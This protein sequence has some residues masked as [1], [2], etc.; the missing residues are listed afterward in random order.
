MFGRLPRGG[1]DRNTLPAT[2]ARKP[3]CRLPRGGVDRN[4]G[5]SIFGR[6]IVTSPPS[7]R[8][9]SKLELGIIYHW[10]KDVASLAEAWIETM[11]SMVISASGSSPPSRRRGSKRERYGEGEFRRRRLPRGGVD[12]NRADVHETTSLG[13][14]LPRGGVDRNLQGQAGQCWS[15]VSP[16]SRRRGS[17]R[18]H[19]ALPAAYVPSPPSRR[20]GSKL[21]KRGMTDALL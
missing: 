16:P 3:L 18:R 1:V 21:C 2:V 15:A 20:R 14:R 12:R 9:G 6:I 8:R 5:V 7:R 17:K 4:F 10:K 13:C 11:S 19:G